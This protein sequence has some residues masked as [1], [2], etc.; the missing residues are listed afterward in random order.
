MKSGPPKS[1]S[2]LQRLL[3]EVY[4]NSARADPRNS[5][6]LASSVLENLPSLLDSL[7]RPTFEPHAFA[8]T[9][10]E[11]GI[12]E[13]LVTEEQRLYDLLTPSRPN[14]V[15]RLALAAS[16]ARGGEHRLDFGYL[17]PH[18][19]YLLQAAEGEA[20]RRQFMSLLRVK[21]QPHGRS[22]L[23]VLSAFE[24][25]ALRFFAY[26]YT[27][28]ADGCSLRSAVLGRAGFRSAGHLLLNEWLAYFRNAPET[29]PG[30]QDTVRLVYSLSEEFLLMP[31]ALLAPTALLP[32]PV[33]AG[34]LACLSPALVLVALPH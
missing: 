20:Y 18:T 11:L 12:R 32:R 25:L 28:P 14:S 6:K 27:A 1:P 17:P 7:L 23:L 15:F 26:L 33:K 19:A 22:G 21:Q 10:R 29:D 2:Q 24:F 5:E 30:L 31:A 9:S 8:S 16:R 4:E 3:E 34:L 13:A